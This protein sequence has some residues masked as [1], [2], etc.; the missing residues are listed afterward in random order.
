MA[1]LSASIG[2]IKD[3]DGKPVDLSA[4]AGGDSKAFRLVKPGYYTAVIEGLAFHENPGKSGTYI[5][6]NRPDGKWVYWRLTPSVRLQN[7][8]GTLIN[9]QDV[10]LGVVENGQY[11]RPDGD[12]TKPAMWST[13]Q[14]FLR[15]LG[16]LIGNNGVYTHS[17]DPE[18]I[19]GRVVR[20]QVAVGAYR[21]G[22]T[23]YTPE[24][25]TAM[26]TQ[27]NNGQGYEFE[28]IPDLV[29]LY[30][31]DNNLTEDDALKTKNVITGYYSVG[32]KEIEE[33]G[34]YVDEM[35]GVYLS[36]AVYK[37]YLD[38]VANPISDV[39]PF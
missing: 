22:S 31:A 9:R 11:I 4:K 24:Q 38:R 15:A 19:E 6:P 17:F 23:S 25:L 35:G 30:N 33:H 21:K 29:A 8:N 13:G 27:T 3:K 26:L 16:L 39:D 32:G 36:E 20:V 37:V 34:Y 14:F 1:M 28:D 7:E 18:L 12:K 5:N 10:Q 2:E